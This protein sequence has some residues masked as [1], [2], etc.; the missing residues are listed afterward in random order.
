M[1]DLKIEGFG[2]VSSLGADTDGRI[3]LALGSHRLWCTA[4]GSKGEGKE[5]IREKV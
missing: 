3:G 4:N 2:L 5:G 1:L